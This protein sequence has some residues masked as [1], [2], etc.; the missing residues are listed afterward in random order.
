MALL[1]VNGR[2]YTLYG[3][4]R[5]GHL[6]LDCN[7][8]VLQHSKTGRSYRRCMRCH[9]IRQQKFRERKKNKIPVDSAVRPRHIAAHENDDFHAR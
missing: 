3:T 8:V 4:C 5:S 2:S 1:I 7:S 9:A 6:L